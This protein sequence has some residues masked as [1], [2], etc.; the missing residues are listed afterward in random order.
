MH[1]H[2]LFYTCVYSLKWVAHCLLQTEQNNTL[3]GS[4]LTLYSKYFLT[5]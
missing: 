1:T 2:I 5:L 4:F 3:N